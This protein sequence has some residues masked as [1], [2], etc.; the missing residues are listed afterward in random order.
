MGKPIPRP[1]PAEKR[2][3]VELVK[4]QRK[5]RKFYAAPCGNAADAMYARAAAWELEAEVKD[6]I[7][8]LANAVERTDNPDC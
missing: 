2:A 6:R 3:R 5:L 1:T 7:R 4:A 8:Q